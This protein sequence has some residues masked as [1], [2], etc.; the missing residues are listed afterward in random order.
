MTKVKICGITNLEDAEMCIGC[1]AD[2]IGFVFTESPR[3]VAV[4]LAR[5][6]IEACGPF[7]I[8]V[9]VFVDKSLEEVRET[10]ARTGCLFAQLHGDEPTEYIQALSPTRVIKTVRVRGRLDERK[11]R[12]YKEVRAILLDTYVAGLAGGTGQQFDPMLAWGL[13]QKGWKVII[14]GGLTSE[15]VGAVV[16]SVR[17][18]A[19]DVSSG[20]EAEPGRKDPDKVMRF[21]AAVRAA[22]GRSS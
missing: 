2:A 5:E 3:Q 11:L 15:N 6:I 1:G 18:Y 7:A 14:A 12:A 9:G 21:I 10:L 16:A 4:E 22:N 8:T 19:V 13:V 17:P 20:V